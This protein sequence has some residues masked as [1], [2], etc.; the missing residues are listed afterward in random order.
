MHKD[1]PMPISPAF[2]LFAGAVAGCSVTPLLRTAIRGWKAGRCQQ[3]GARHKGSA[4]PAAQVSPP[5][6]A[7]DATPLTDSRRYFVRAPSGCV[8]ERW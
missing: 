2:T 5:A 1:A 3:N 6:S 7:R 4:G 8:T